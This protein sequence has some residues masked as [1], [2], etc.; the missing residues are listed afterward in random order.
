[1][2]STELTFHPGA[3]RAGEYVFSIGTAGS[4]TLVLQTVLLPLALADGPSRM[5]LEGGTHN[6]FAPPF[7]FLAAAYVP[8]LNRMGPRVQVTLERPGFYPAGGGRIVVEIEPTKSLAGFELME[9]GV[10]RRRLACAQI[11]RLPGH[12]ADRELKVLAKKLN[13][14][15]RQLERREITDSAGPGNLVTIELEYEQVTEVFTGFGE[16]HRPAE[17]VANQAVQQC[18]RYL[19][20]TAPVGEY[21]TDQ[22]MLP[23][24]LSGGGRFVSTGLSRHA[25]THLALI[26]EFLDVA[27]R[28]EQREDGVTVSFES[29]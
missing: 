2:R 10:L 1:M 19:K 16:V 15:D 22:L 21:L 5:T 6:P 25:K 13:W 29:G 8:L 11:A 24:A 12:I 20:S 14:P 9:R 27:A 3:V 7:D 4:T 26:G 28:T 23:L 18:Q 17:A